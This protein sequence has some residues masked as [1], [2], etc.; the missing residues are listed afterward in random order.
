MSR[1]M[2]RYFFATVKEIFSIS[3]NEPTLITSATSFPYMQEYIDKFEL[4][5]N[6]FSSVNSSWRLYKYHKVNGAFPEDILSRVRLDFMSVLAI[7]DYKYKKLFDTLSLKYNPI[8]NY[9]MTEHEVGTRKD[10]FSNVKSEDLNKN[11]HLGEVV[12]NSNLVVGA[13][14]NIDT[15]SV[16]PMNGGYVNK[17]KVDTT[18]G[19]RTDVTNFSQQAITNVEDVNNEI[20]EKNTGTQDTDRTLT[21]SGNIGVTTSQQMIMSERDVA[22][23]SFYDTIWN[24]FLDKFAYLG[25]DRMVSDFE[26]CF[27]QDYH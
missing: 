23:F 12:G 10:D 6:Y 4:F 26:C 19:S 13:Q 14:T 5:D 16:S 20:S 21:R 9:D 7:N 25:D 1:Q 15:N 24:D 8:N 11:T 18:I 17:E 27:L 22:L 2:S 3:K